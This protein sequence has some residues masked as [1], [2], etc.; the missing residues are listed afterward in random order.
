MSLFGVLAG[1]EIRE[2]L[3]T[4]RVIILPAVFVFFGVF[5]GVEFIY[6]QF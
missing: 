6:F 3:K 2:L 1:K 4:L 5:G